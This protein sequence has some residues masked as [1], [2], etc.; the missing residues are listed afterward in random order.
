MSENALSHIGHAKKYCGLSGISGTKNKISQVGNFTKG[1]LYSFLQFSHTYFD[2]V[3][4]IL[5]GFVF[6][7]NIMNI[8]LNNL[9]PYIIIPHPLTSIGR[10]PF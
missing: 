4:P 9:L 3:K 6:Q 1:Q 7:P 5:E 8:H 10:Y 2:L